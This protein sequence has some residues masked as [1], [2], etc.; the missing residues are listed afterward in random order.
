MEIL[1]FKTLH[2]IGNLN[3]GSFSVDINIPFDVDE[4]VLKHVSMQCDE[5]IDLLP[6][7]I[8]STNLINDILCVIPQ[9]SVFFETMNTP[10]N[11]INHAVQGLYTFTIIG[12]NN[13]PPTFIY[14]VN[15][16]LVLLFVQ[17]KKSKLLL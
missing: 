11:R 8:I 3:P 7:N 16:C 12:I 6:L 9:T 14:D 10:F 13:Q 1:N 5:A 17:Y 15:I 4:I 2:V